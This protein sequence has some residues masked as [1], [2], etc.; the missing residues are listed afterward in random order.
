M[1]NITS[2]QHKLSRLRPPRVQITYDVE[3]GDAVEVR[4]LP[5]LVGIMSDLSGKSEIEKTKVKDRKFIDLNPENFNEV[6]ESIEPRVN[7]AV[8]NKLTDEGGRLGVDLKFKHMNDFD[9]LNVVKQIPALRKLFE[10]RGN[11]VDLLSKLD[12]NEE[13]DEMLMSIVQNTPELEEIK[14]AVTEAEVEGED[15]EGDEEPGDEE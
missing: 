8:P 12:G 4:E 7:Y 1:S 15:S 10:V 13:L 9:P 6:L 14:A 11:L 2:T 5:L 3:I